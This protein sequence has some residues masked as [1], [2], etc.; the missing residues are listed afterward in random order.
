M[1]HGVPGTAEAIKDTSRV[2]AREPGEK[3][4]PG[5]VW[6]ESCVV[7]MCVY[8]H[9]TVRQGGGKPYS[10]KVTPTALPLDWN[11][12]DFRHM[13]Y[14]FKFGSNFSWD[15]SCIAIN[16][17]NSQKKDYGTRELEFKILFGHCL[18]SRPGAGSQDS[19]FQ[20]EKTQG[21]IWTFM[22]FG[23]LWWSLNEAITSCL[24]LTNLPWASPSCQ[25]LKW[26]SSSQ[27]SSFSLTEF[28]LYMNV[29]VCSI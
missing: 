8:W 25:V 21:T 27:H 24:Q 22:H 5:K 20:L 1:S 11:V 15:I 19:V 16:I 26:G 4:Q 3:K 18:P 12:S 6:S 17:E 28:S 9:M 23:W 7:C 13:H 14:E 2:S 29:W 10:P